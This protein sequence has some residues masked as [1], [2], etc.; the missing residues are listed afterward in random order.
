MD[1]LFLD[2]DLPNSSGFEV[3][4]SIRQESTV[5]KDT[6]IV[7]MAIKTYGVHDSKWL[8]SGMDIF[9]HTDAALKSCLDIVRTLNQNT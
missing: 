5:N 4:K 3:A 6:H 7:G 2:A 9:L 1:V 8:N